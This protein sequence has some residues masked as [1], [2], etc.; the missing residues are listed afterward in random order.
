MEP[1]VPFWR[2]RFCVGNL[3]EGKKLGDDRSP[4]TIYT[5][6]HKLNSIYLSVT[7]LALVTLSVALFG[8]LVALPDAA[9]AGKRLL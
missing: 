8:G 6:R 5:T 7:M 9:N 2:M 1:C 3:N 4:S